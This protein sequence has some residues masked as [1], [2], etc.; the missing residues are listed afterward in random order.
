M[1]SYKMKSDWKEMKAFHGK[2]IVELHYWSSVY[3]ITWY[4][5]FPN[6]GY[7]MRANGFYLR[8]CY[9]N[10]NFLLIL[11]TLQTTNTAL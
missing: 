7:I 10:D 4:F 2:C 8:K 6:K 3:Q 9:H 5:V 11:Q 1:S